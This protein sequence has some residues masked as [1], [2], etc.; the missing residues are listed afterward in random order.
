MFV[1][2]EYYKKKLSLSIHHHG[3]N[4]TGSRKRS[5][6]NLS[7]HGENNEQHKAKYNMFDM[8]GIDITEQYIHTVIVYGI[9]TLHCIEDMFTIL[10]IIIM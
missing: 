4:Y 3:N 1:H 6:L 2:V 9:Y 10:G 5:S 7:L 8:D